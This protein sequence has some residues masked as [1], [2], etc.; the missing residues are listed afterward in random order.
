P[1]PSVG[2]NS[3]PVLCI[4]GDIGV[5][6]FGRAV[7][8][9]I[10]KLDKH[11]DRFHITRRLLVS[12]PGWDSLIEVAIVANGQRWHKIIFYVVQQRPDGQPRRHLICGHRLRTDLSY[13]LVTLEGVLRDSLVGFDGLHPDELTG[14]RVDTI[15]RYPLRAP[16]LDGKFT[17]KPL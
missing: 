3:I 9:D 16:V 10:G 1:E 4:T 6:L 8:T 14:V 2:F 13:P 17:L 15:N 5:R 12:A 7:M 11:H